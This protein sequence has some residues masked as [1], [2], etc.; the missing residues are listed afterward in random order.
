MHRCVLQSVLDDLE[1][2]V[3]L[4]RPFAFLAEDVARAEALGKAIYENDMVPACAVWSVPW[5]VCNILCV[6]V[7]NAD[8]CVCRRVGC[9]RGPVLH[10]EADAGRRLR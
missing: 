9:S 10:G 7:S 1:L 6:A 4:A 8:L 3:S 2:A 5:V